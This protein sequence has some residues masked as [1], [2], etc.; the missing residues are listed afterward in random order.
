[1]F[2]E[3]TVAP[4]NWRVEMEGILP[5]L[6]TFPSEWEVKTTFGLSHHSLHP[7]VMSGHNSCISFWG[8]YSIPM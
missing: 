5:S 2:R 4:N 6:L 8:S 1:M 7:N 3:P